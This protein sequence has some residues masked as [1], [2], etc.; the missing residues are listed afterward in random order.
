MRPK[1]KIFATKLARALIDKGVVSDR[2]TALAVAESALRCGAKTKTT[3]APCRA[4]G[5]LPSLRCPLHGGAG[6]GPWTPA[7][8]EAR[9]QGYQ[10]WL[11][12]KQAEREKMKAAE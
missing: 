11:A 1:L 4:K 7:G 10:R 5:M 2:Q 3:G 6:T 8:L 9:R 12:N